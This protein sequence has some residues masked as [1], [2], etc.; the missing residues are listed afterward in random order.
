MREGTDILEELGPMYSAALSHHEAFVEMLAGEPAAAEARLRDGYARLGEMGEKALLATTAA[1]LAQAL[2]RQDRLEE[3]ERLCD[4]S[5]DA[6]AGDD[7]SAQVLW[8]V[9]RAK[10]LARQDRH[11]EAEALARE[12][13][14]LVAK[15][16]Y[17]TYHGDALLDLA[18]VLQL[19]GRPDDAEEA[20]RGALDLYEEKGNLVSAER[21]R[22]RLPA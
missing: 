16:D 11:E 20:V 2:Y 17:L 4:V 5:R 6:A 14:E 21:A 1:M 7:L 22:S 8:R 3:A 12:A 13:V 18:E 9:V 15:T 19:G 10:I